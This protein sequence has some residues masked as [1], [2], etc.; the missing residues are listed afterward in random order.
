[1]NVQVKLFAAARQAVGKTTV[2]VEL[3]RDTTVGGLRRQL[4][5]AYPALETLAPHLS[6]A[7]NQQYAPDDYVLH[8]DEEIACFPPVSGG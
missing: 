5:A 8:D 6:V 7:V 3:D 4:I 1:M 2:E